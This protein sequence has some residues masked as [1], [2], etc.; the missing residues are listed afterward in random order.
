MKRQ[1]QAARGENCRRTGEEPQQLTG[2]GAAGKYPS[3]SRFCRLEESFAYLL[4]KEAWMGR[5]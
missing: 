5:R 2:V 3:S 4:R 1:Q